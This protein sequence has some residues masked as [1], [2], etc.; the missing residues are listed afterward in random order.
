MEE[1]EERERAN[2]AHV[3][4]A[5]ERLTHAPGT[6]SPSCGTQAPL[7]ASRARGRRPGPG[8]DDQERRGS[9]DSRHER[10]GSSEPWIIRAQRSHG[11][12]QATEGG[13]REGSS[14]RAPGDQ[15]SPLP[16]A[17]GTAPPAPGE[18]HRLHQN[19]MLACFH[20]VSARAQQCT[21]ASSLPCL[22]AHPGAPL[23]VP[24]PTAHL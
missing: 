10:T 23:T 2:L 11:S 17:A 5:K 1:E 21:W 12:L 24:N 20:L 19:A 3:A 8:G 14:G 6:S 7:P 9:Q 13:R 15:A 18:G 22:P 16:G 4:D